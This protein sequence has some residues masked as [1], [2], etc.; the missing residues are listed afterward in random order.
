TGFFVAPRAYASRLNESIYSNAHRVADYIITESGLGID[1]G[2]ALGPSTEIRAGY[3]LGW[4]KGHTAIGDP[5]IPS[6]SGRVNSL[7]A[8]LQVERLD[9][10]VIPTRGLR[11]KTEGWWYLD[12]PG[13]STQFP[14]VELRTLFAQPLN[15][16]LSALVTVRGGT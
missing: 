12:S 15:R 9:D 2:Y 7:S 8:K 13:S 14:Q 6:F 10:P 11:I 16:R 4:Q 5:G 1:L 3:D